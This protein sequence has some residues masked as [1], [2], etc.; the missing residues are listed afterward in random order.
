MCGRCIPE[1]LRAV[2]ALQ[3]ADEENVATPANWIPNNPVLVPSPTTF[4]GLLERTKQIEENRN[5]MN[6]YLSF[7]N[8]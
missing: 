5:G 7:K 3:V 1:I 8:L 2:Q 4:N 6:W